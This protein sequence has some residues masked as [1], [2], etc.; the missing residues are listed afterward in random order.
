MQRLFITGLLSVASVASAQKDTVVIHA[1]APVHRNGGV[2]VEVS[3]LGNGAAGDEY[4]FS[5]AFVYPGLHGAIFVLD[6]RDPNNVGDF[7]ST[8]RQYDSTGKYLRTFGRIGDGPGEYRHGIG[9][10]AQL[11]DGR[12]LVAHWLGVNVYSS[13]ARPLD[14][15]RLPDTLSFSVGP[16]LLLDANGDVLVAPWSVYRRPGETR[17]IGE[18]Y[19]F[20]PNGEYVGVITD[21]RLEFAVRP[22]SFRMR[23]MRV[24]FAPAYHTAWSQAGYFITGYGGAYAIDLRRPP[25]GQRR[26]WQAGDPIVSI[27]RSTPAI[28]VA[29]AERDDWRATVTLFSRSRVSGGTPQWTWDG[30]SIPETKPLLRD[31]F[32]DQQTRIW[33][34]TSTTAVLRP[35]VKI[36]ANPAGPH[37][38]FDQNVAMKRWVEPWVFD[39][40]EASGRYL[41]EVRF[42][43][44]AGHPDGWPAPAFVA[45][46]DTVWAV[47]YDSEAVPTVKKYRIRW[48]D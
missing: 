35:D 28:A 47:T 27:R 9:S 19:R 32:V 5:N 22:D 41:G 4:E 15:W 26:M 20:R 17:V 24:P 29:P 7:R 11:P 23:A 30:P 12:V 33:A 10:V 48:R 37:D 18:M 3:T 46:G 8:V 6:L 40:F 43:D 25:A 1:G 21:P 2:L 39:V 38:G 16:R 34:R 45:V 36:P 42:P 44:G 31:L 14:T 13:D